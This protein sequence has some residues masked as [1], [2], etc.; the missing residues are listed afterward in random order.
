MLEHPFIEIASSML[1]AAPRRR[2]ASTE[3]PPG[4]PG[5]FK[6]AR[7]AQCRY[8]RDHNRRGRRRLGKNRDPRQFSRTTVRGVLYECIVRLPVP[9]DILADRGPN[10]QG[11]TGSDVADLSMGA[12]SAGLSTRTGRRRVWTMSTSAGRCRRGFGED[13]VTEVE[14]VAGAA[15][16]L[17]RGSAGPGARFRR[18]GRSRTT[19]SRLP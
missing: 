11:A 18:A 5:Q 13:A 16:G 3:V 19:G 8:R 9:G 4:H 10:G 12:G 6:A 2:G 1:S 7:A 17:G 15:A 14:D